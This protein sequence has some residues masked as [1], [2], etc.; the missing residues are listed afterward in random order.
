MAA[1][2]GMTSMEQSVSTDASEA[3]FSV[4]A[5][6]R[7]TLVIPMANPRRPTFERTLLVKQQKPSDGRA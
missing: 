5:S 4:V 6:L 3:E 7:N 2:R 1:V